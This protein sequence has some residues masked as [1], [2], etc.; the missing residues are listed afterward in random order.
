MERISDKDLEIVIKQLKR[1]VSNVLSVCHRCSYGFPTVI[2]SYPIRD[3][4][5]F[6]T[7]HYLTCPYL[8][9]EISRL[10]E[11]GLIA[12]FEKRIKSDE[13]LRKAYENAHKEVINKRLSLLSKDDERWVGLLSVVGTGGIRDFTAVKCLHLHVADYLAGINN[14]VGKQVYESLNQKECSDALCSRF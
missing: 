13:A 10:E 11:K 14:P 12:E 2:L 7:I 3:G 6:P 8:T 9:K 5:P 4:V 1:G